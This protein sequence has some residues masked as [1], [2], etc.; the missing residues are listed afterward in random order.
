[1]NSIC[2]TFKECSLDIQRWLTKQ[3]EVKEESITDRFLYDLSEKISSIKY[4]QFTRTEEGRKTGADWEWWF[5]FSNKNS[6]AARVQAKKLKNKSD[7]YTGIAYVSNDM[8]QI[9][10]LLNDSEQDGL[11]SFYA[12]YTSEFFT[13]T[14][15]GKQTTDEGIFLGEANKLKAEFILKPRRVLAPTDILRFTNPISCLFCCPLTFKAG[16]NI[17]Q[18]FRQ[19]IKTYYRNFS[20]NT[21]RASNVEEL[22]FV[23]TPNYIL[24]FLSAKL[25]DYWE[26]EYRTR[27][28]KTNALVVIDLRDKTDNFR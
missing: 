5:I 17:L 22:G 1:M 26:I 16:T 21:Q 7:N 19:Y 4:K 28:E 18:G 12:F 3:P 27:F 10:R 23:T 8:L 24:E 14:M 20:D 25:E 9:E 13:N 2:Q 15:C 6:F 11:A